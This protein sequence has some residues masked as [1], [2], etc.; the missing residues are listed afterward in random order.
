MRNQNDFKR[1]VNNLNKSKRKK[2]RMEL[3]LSDFYL[4][5]LEE[6]GT[7]ILDSLVLKI[8]EQVIQMNLNWRNKKS[9]FMKRKIKG[10]SEFY[11][12]PQKGDFDP[13]SGLKDSEA[14]EH[15]LNWQDFSKDY[16]KL[17]SHSF[18]W[19][20]YNKS[21]SIKVDYFSVKEFFKE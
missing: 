2:E 18:L 14:I 20:A 6:A 15:I 8:F 3:A 16:V 12:F 13:F 4:E 21:K 11:Y 9:G 1:V 19:E 10:F 5:H 7:R 17:P